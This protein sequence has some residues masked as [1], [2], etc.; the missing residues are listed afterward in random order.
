MTNN[1]VILMD[2]KFKMKKT[3]KTHRK[4]VIYIS[5]KHI[6][7]LLLNDV[8]FGVILF[9]YGKFRYKKLI[10]SAVR[11]NRHT[12]T[13]F[14]RSPEQLKVLEKQI[15]DFKPFANQNLNIAVFA[16][17]NGAEAYTLSS[18]LG[19]ANPNLKF[20]IICSDLH[21]DNID[22]AIKAV[23]DKSAL[24]SPVGIPNDFIKH[25]FNIEGENFVV[26]DRVKEKVSFK[27]SDL[28]DSNLPDAFSKY[29]IVFLQNVLFH[30]NHEDAEF[31][32]RNILKVMKPNALLFVD[33]ME[34]DMKEKLTFE[35]GL[36]PVDEKIAEIYSSSRKHIPQ[37]WWNYY[38]GNEPYSIFNRN[39][40]RRF[41]TIFK[42]EQANVS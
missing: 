4:N 16:G 2:E 8:L 11:S 38:Y 34:L 20:D 25:T 6:Y 13:S 10:G 7:Q 39:N 29:D 40:N 3:N 18:Y 30:L 32:F 22:Y 12:Y 14:Y 24:S 19:N 31:A 33:G 5:L 36:I 21:K 27:V 26:K 28:L 17:S 15:N 9:H 1:I 23:Y 37:D 41:C 35:N 42:K